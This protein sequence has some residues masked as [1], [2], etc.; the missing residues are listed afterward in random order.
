MFWPAPAAFAELDAL[1]SD[2][3]DALED[4]SVDDAPA[5]AGFASAT[6][7]IAAIPAPMPKKTA[8]APTRPM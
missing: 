2:A 3:S 6:P 1:L 5:S 4:V 7:G 8:N